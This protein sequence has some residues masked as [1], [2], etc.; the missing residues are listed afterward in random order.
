MEKED[1]SVLGPYLAHSMNVQK[2][3]TLGCRKGSETRIK[4]V[5]IIKPRWLT[6]KYLLATNYP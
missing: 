5:Q 2:T 4:P 3:S 6:N 1:S